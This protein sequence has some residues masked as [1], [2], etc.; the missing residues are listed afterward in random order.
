MHEFRRRIDEA[1]EKLAEKVE[2]SDKE[3]IWLCSNISYFEDDVMSPCDFC[4]KYVYHRPFAVGKKICFD[5]LLENYSLGEIG[6]MTR[7]FLDKLE[8]VEESE[9]NE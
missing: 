4:G 5:C 6:K 7:N 3:T 1:L 9:G 2:S 8:E